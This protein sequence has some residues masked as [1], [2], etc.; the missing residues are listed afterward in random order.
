MSVA[1]QDRHARTRQVEH[2]TLVARESLIAIVRDRHPLRPVRELRPSPLVAVAVPVADQDVQ[3]PRLEEGARVGPF[4]RIG[5]DALVERLVVEDLERAVESGAVRGGPGGELVELADEARELLS[6]FA[7]GGIV[8]HDHQPLR[9]VED[10]GRVHELVG[11]EEGR[12][13]VGRDLI[14]HEIARP[15]VTQL[16]GKDAR[17]VLV[18]RTEGVVAAVRSPQ[19][20]RLGLA[21]PYDLDGHEPTRDRVQAEG[22]DPHRRRPQ[23]PVVLAPQP[24]MD[25]A[26]LVLLSD[27]H[28]S[29]RRGRGDARVLGARRPR[30]DR[31]REN[32]RRD[33][34]PA[35]S[36]PS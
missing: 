13:L 2:E 17:G 22:L 27:H 21:A 26:L 7:Q 30:H 32:A 23:G 10:S 4:P 18:D 8:R 16:L 11:H 6:E 29:S 36:L 9:A 14:L 15:C 5:R 34:R 35:A 19:R 3:E 20:E 12:R 24:A 28:R 31:D 33:R 25:A 1:L